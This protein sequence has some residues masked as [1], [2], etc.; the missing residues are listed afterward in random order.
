M[1]AVS[2]ASHA[3]DKDKVEQVSTDTQP[4]LVTLT[5][6]TP[7]AGSA[8]ERRRQWQRRYRTRLNI[9]DV[10]VVLIA[11]SAAFAIQIATI[12]RTMVVD[13]PFAYSR[14]AICTAVIWLLLLV[15]FQTRNT[16]VVGQGAKE[17]QRV[18]HATGLA[19]GILAIV[20]VV[21]Q[22][23]GIRVQLLV[24]LPLG[25]LGLLLGRW[26]LRRWLVRQ[27]A[28]GDYVSR[29]LVVGLRRD[30][31]QVVTAVHS[32]G[33][34]GYRVVGVSMNDDSS[35]TLAVNGNTFRAVGSADTAHLTAEKLGADAVIVASFPDND[36][37]YVKRLSWQL[38]GTASELVLSS[39]LVD[40]AG[41]RMALRPMEG[42]P[43][44][45]VEIPVF[46]GARY[47][48]KR[49]M[50]IVLSSLALLA[51]AAITPFVWAAIK[52]DDRGPVF[53]RQVRIGRDG[54]RFSM[55]KFRSMGTDAE[56]KR[57]S[58]LAS[59]EGAG[60]LFKM[61]DDPRVTRV[62]TFLRKYSLDE[63]PQFWNVL[64]GDMSIVGPRPPLPAEAV[65]YDGTV[66]RR[67]YIKPGITG[68]WQV[69]GRS[70]LSWEE[71]VRLDL[72]YVENW[73]VMGDVM[74]M[75]Q[76]AAVMVHADGAY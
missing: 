49:G 32:S 31:E 13:D 54:E 6:L 47:T 39:P 76:T 46:E 63:L 27:R 42:L 29:A 3:L 8:V 20:F 71:S 56:A 50:D 36:P 10:L 11:V 41:P 35:P 17:Y 38:E 15:I 61:K 65:E 62:G 22:S 25:I 70:D 23:Q 68:P 40:V 55:V 59:D 45:H 52:L 67:L 5:D 66:S 37:Q 19:F 48:I 74:I 69:G 60:L 9:V 72:R 16:R 21:V 57:A 43:L 33:V 75:W 12:D 73:S 14:V 18:A 7:R 44:I 51:V 2:H 34:L 30:V 24:A 28:T 64:I 58:L 1:S 53:F 26:L 4:R